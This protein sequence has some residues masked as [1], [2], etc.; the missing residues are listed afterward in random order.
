M[1]EERVV[2]AQSMEGL[3]RALDPLTAQERAAF[4]KA[5]VKKPGDFLPAYPLLQYIEILDACAAS[6]F[7]SLNE[8]ERY[9]E[10]GRLFFSGFERTLIGAAMVTMLKV[11]GPKRTLDR[12]TRNFR[13]ANNFTDGLVESLA[14]N[15]HYVR[16]NYTLRPGFYL[17]LLDSG[18]RRA[19]AQ[20]LT[21]KL[22]QSKDFASTYELRWT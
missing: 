22:L 17:G 14:P 20:G 16:I 13:T 19:G 5:G 1:S 4:L 10:V 6:R 12:M 18:C 21:T 11:L 3:W 15:H 2:F 8:L 7:A 9:T